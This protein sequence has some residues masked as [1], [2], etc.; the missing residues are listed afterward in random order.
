[1]EKKAIFT[2]DWE[3]YYNAVEAIEKWPFCKNLIEEPTL[4]LLDLLDEYNIKAIFYVLGYTRDTNIDLYEEI[5]ASGHVIGSHGYWHGHNEK[6]DGLFRSPYWDCT[7]LP[8]LCG[9]FFFR[10]LP[11]KILKCEINRTDMFYIHPHDIMLSHPIL[12]NMLF[13]FKRH[14]GLKGAREKL[15]RL[16]KEIKWDDPTN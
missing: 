8:G 15:E 7:P 9:G 4:Y 13:N 5:E 14:F 11:Y 6:E 1:V 3:D 2:V 16:C 10:T 12:S